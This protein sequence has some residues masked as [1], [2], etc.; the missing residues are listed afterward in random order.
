MTTVIM[1]SYRH[2]DKNTSCFYQLIS[3][4]LFDG[5]SVYGIMRYYGSYEDGTPNMT[6]TLVCVDDGTLRSYLKAYELF[7]KL[8]D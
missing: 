3:S 4:T 5:S 1:Q 8:V 6:V 2:G 7:R